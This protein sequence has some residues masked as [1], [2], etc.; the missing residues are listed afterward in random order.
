MSSNKIVEI[1]C[2]ECGVVGKAKQVI[3]GLPDDDFDFEKYAV[4]GCIIEDGA[5]NLKCGE[6]GARWK[7]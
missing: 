5:P 2:I 1:V 6:C 7:G 3:Y 4:G